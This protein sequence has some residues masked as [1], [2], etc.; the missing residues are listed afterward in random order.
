MKAQEYFGIVD[1][2][3]S[4]EAASLDLPY[5]LCKLKGDLLLIE[6]AVNEVSLPICV[7]LLISI[8]VL[9]W[10]AMLALVR[11]TVHN[12]R[13][14]C[15]VHDCRLPCPAHCSQLQTAVRAE[16]LKARDRWLHSVRDARVPVDLMEVVRFFI[17]NVQLSWLQDWYGDVVRPWDRSVLCAEP[18]PEASHREAEQDEVQE[19]GEQDEAHGGEGGEGDGTD[20]TTNDTPAGFKVGDV[21]EARAQGYRR[22][23]ECTILKVLD[24]GNYEIKWAVDPQTDT[25][26]KPSQVRKKKKARASRNKEQQVAENVQSLCN[27]TSSALLQRVVEKEE[28]APVSTAKVAIVVYSFDEAVLYDRVVSPQKSRPVTHVE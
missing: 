26:K 28:K 3:H 23:W 27:D 8:C 6:R 2:L 24:D 20:V 5:S 21:V 4:A 15:L 17:E 10:V 14:P 18:N 16:F 13:Q 22:W 25:I 12:C 19:E 7:W 11:L 1:A 9:C